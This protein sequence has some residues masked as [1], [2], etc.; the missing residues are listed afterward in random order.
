[1]NW[2][3]PAAAA[4]ALLLGAR[5]FA[6][7]LDEYLQAA[8]ISVEKDRVQVSMRLVPGVAVSSSVLAVIDTNGDGV[9]SRAEQRAYAER[10]L[11]DLSLT[12]EGTR[13]SPRLVSV[14]FPAVEEMKA[15]LGE[16]RIELS[17]NLPPGGPNRRLVLQNTHQGRIAAYL[18][19]C[20]VPRD[21][22]IRIAAQSRNEQQSVYRVDYVVR[23]SRAA[24]PP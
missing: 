17:A 22:D 12:A 6:H 1:V 9:I 15:G 21:P 7:R 13:L 8:L 23:S 19:N 11:G 24:S 16:I 5:A 14:H 20:L 3:L 4:I 2:K 10:V 18:M